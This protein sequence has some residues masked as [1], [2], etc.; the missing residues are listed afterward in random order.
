M[1]VSKKTDITTM[2]MEYYERTIK[3]VVMVCFLTLQKCIEECR[4]ENGLEPKASLSQTVK[5]AQ[6]GDKYRFASVFQK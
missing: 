6:E 1:F 3:I 4:V 2:F 5:T